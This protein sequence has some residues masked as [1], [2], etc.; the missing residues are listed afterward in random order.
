MALAESGIV[1]HPKDTV[2]IDLDTA[3]SSPTGITILK[4][5]EV[6]VIMNDQTFSGLS[7][8]LT[9]GEALKD[10]GIS[11]QGLD[12]ANPPENS[13]LP[14]NRQI[15]L[16]RVQET[17]SI[18]KVETPYTNSYQPD[19]NTELDQGSVI[20]PGQVGLAITRSRIQ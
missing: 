3:L 11:L 2:S 14:A 4:A 15:Q 9:V 19:P 18:V 8:A 10:L 5:R 1:I 17:L 6:A 7:S 16:T 20:Q 12:Y 13:P